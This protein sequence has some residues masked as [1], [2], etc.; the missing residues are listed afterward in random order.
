METL[1]TTL[2]TIASLK[3]AGTP[4]AAAPAHVRAF[5]AWRKAVGGATFDAEAWAHYAAGEDPAAFMA[6]RESAIRDDGR[7]PWC[8][9]TGTRQ[10]YRHISLGVCFR[11][12]GTGVKGGR[13]DGRRTVR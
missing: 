10:E 12:N 13:S 2:A 7:C 9:G 4:L 11:C 1:E 3:T 5:I 6:A 8:G